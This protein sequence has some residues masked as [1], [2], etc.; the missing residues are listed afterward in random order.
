MI[1]TLRILTGNDT[2][3]LEW[4]RQFFR[5]YA[6][7][8]GVDLCF[9]NFEEEMASLPG[10]Y[11]APEGRL[12]YA[13]HDGQPAGCV[14]IR[15]LSAGLCEMK[16][17]YVEPSRRGFRRRPRSDAGGDH[18]SQGDRLPQTSARHAAGDA[19]RGQALS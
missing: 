16:R 9:Q 14:G 8:L 2:S 7:W 18:G 11:S 5:N 6:G 19:C 10:A 12:F 15:P 3:E 13:E 17:L 4:V 1:N